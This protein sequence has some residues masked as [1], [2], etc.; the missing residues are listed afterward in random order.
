LTGIILSIRCAKGTKH[1]FKIFKESGLEINK[2]ARIKADKGFQGILK[3]FEKAQ[4]PF[5]A[6]KHKPLSKEQKQYNRRLA[7]ERILI[8]HINRECKIFRICKEQYRGKHKNYER[9]WK[10]VAAIV[11]LKRATRHLK[12]ATPNVI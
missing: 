9:T 4:L 12:F 2:N 8:E 1:D 7:K 11:N 10:L 5:K 6:S 3:L